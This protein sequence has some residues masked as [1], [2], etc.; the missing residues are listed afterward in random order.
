MDRL[1]APVGVTRLTLSRIPEFEPPAE[2]PAM[3]TRTWRLRLM[4]EQLTLDFDV[5]PVEL[6]L[7][8]DRR[9]VAALMPY[10]L[11]GLAGR[12]PLEHLDRFTAPP[13]RTRLRQLAQGWRR[14]PFIP[15]AYRVHTCRIG[16]GVIEASCTLRWG[17]N[18][19]R[20]MT[21]RLHRDGD[22]WTCAELHL[23]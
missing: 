5:E 21:L 22:S 4:P 15:V 3:P 13:A 9:A 19:F 2:Y 10:L 20:V 1:R 7:P 12:R 23:L 16:S 11:E 17:D 18:R 14:L 6:C 8:E